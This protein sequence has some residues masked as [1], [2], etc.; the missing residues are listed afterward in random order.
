M[1]DP[2]VA[3]GRNRG[4]VVHPRE[5]AKE[6]VKDAPSIDPET[7]LT[8]ELEADSYQHFGLEYRPVGAGA[9][10]QRSTPTL[11]SKIARR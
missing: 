1:T 6:R 2:V 5:T 7:E 9:P 3:G 8:S 4:A 11:K 10:D